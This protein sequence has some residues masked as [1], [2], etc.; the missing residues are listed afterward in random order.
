ML[1]LFFARP[2][3]EIPAN[4][5]IAGRRNSSSRQ[6]NARA[7]AVLVIRLFAQ[8][9]FAQK[10]KDGPY[11]LCDRS[12]CGAHREYYGA[13]PGPVPMAVRILENFQ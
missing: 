7:A 5:G 11:P 1:D 3:T 12:Y 13:D 2:D 6:R 4:A 10:Y 9:Y 8:K